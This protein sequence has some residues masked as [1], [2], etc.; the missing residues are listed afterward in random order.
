MNLLLTAKVGG[1]WTMN[2][3]NGFCFHNA[4]LWMSTGKNFC[5]PS[6]VH[7]SCQGL[8]SRPGQQIVDQRHISCPGRGKEQLRL[9]SG[10]ALRYDRHSFFFS[11]PFFFPEAKTNVLDSCS[12][13]AS[14]RWHTDR[15]S[16]TSLPLRPSSSFSS[17]RGCS[18]LCGKSRQ[19][20]L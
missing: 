6:S 8:C 19:D 16:R 18:E 20:P 17:I 4:A 10:V 7:F 9:L 13:L 12:G 1:L 15:V 14:G 5:L 3:L 11:K 2:N